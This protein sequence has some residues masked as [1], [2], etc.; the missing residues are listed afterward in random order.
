[1]TTTDERIAAVRAAERS[2]YEHQR[3]LQETDPL[4]PDMLRLVLHSWRVPNDEDRWCT[5]CGGAY[6]GDVNVHLV[7]GEVSPAIDTAVCGPCVELIGPYGE[8][9]VKVRGVLEDIDYAMAI[10]PA[11][12]RWTIAALI[13][14]ASGLVSRA[15]HRVE[16]DELVESVSDT[17]ERL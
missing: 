15:Y 3:R 1:M 13:D 11:E 17:I 6:D 12:R 4:D 10:A 7:I 5:R 9:L 16:I 8:A 14:N 2:H